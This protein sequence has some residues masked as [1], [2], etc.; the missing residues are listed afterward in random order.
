MGGSRTA[1]PLVDEHHHVG[2]CRRKHIARAFDRECSPYAFDDHGA[3]IATGV[4]VQPAWTDT[5]GETVG[6]ER[7]LA[8]SER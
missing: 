7:V 3:D 8:A 6:T 1:R 4:E 2:P 5:R